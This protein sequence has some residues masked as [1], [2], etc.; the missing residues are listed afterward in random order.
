ME[1][2]LITEL[3][4]THQSTMRQGQTV[5][6]HLHHFHQLDVVYAG[7]LLTMIEG[8]RPFPVRAGEALLVPPLVRH[9]FRA[10]ETV[11]HAGFKFHVAPAFWPVLGVKARRLRLPP[12]VLEEVR[13]WGV[14]LGRRSPLHPHLAVAVVTICLVEMAQ[15]FPE[16]AIRAD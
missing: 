3:L 16:R 15:A 10:L 12:R 2:P 6:P 1:T 9:S 13:A 4:R 14:Q 5:G 8:R 7:E 11:R